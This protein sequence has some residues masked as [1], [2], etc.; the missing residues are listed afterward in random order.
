MKRNARLAKLRTIE[1]CII[2]AIQ[3]KATTLLEAMYY[4]LNQARRYNPNDVAPPA[5]VIWTDADGQWE[6][7][8]PELQELMPELLILGEYDPDSKQGPA[9]WI[10]CVVD[11]MLDI[12]LPSKTIPV[13]YLPRVPRQTLRAAEEC[14]DMLKPLVE[15]QYRGMVWTQRNGKDWTVEAMLVS[16]DGLGLDVAKDRQTRQ[17][18][19]VALSQLAVTPIERLRGKRLEAEDFDRLMLGD[20]ERELLLWIN[21]PV[22]TKGEWGDEKWAAFCSRCRADYGFDPESDGELV[23]AEKLGLKEKDRWQSL[24]AR[25][26]EAP[27]LYPGIPDKLR[28]AKP[29]SLVFDY[30][31][32][33]DFNEAEE[34]SLREDLSELEKSS[35]V[36]ARTRIKVLE[37]RHGLRREWVWA[38]LGESPLAIALEHLVALAEITTRGIGGSSPEEMA[39]L[40]IEGGYQADH[41]ALMAMGSIRTAEDYGAIQ[42]AVRSIYLPWLEDASRHLQDLMAN[43]PLPN[44]TSDAE[45]LVIAEPGQCLLFVD[46]L[47]F[48][49]AQRLIAMA[50]ARQLQTNGSWRWAG[51]PTVTSTAKPIVS[52]IRNQL[53]GEQPGEDFAPRIRGSGTILDSN[54]LK[55]L[56][57]EAGYQVL[58][59]SIVEQPDNGTSRGWAEE[60]EFDRLGHT[61][62]G[63]LATQLDEQLELVL[64]RIQGLLMSGWR[65]VRVIT[66]HGWLLVPGGLPATSLPKYLT[67]SRWARCA[68]IGPDTYVDAPTYGWYWNKYYSVAFAPGVSCFV[69]GNDYAHGGVS[70]QEC[71]IPDLTFSLSAVPFTDVD[72]SELKWVGMRCRVVTDA[73]SGDIMADLR[74]KP[75]DAGSSIT[76]PKK[77][78]ADGRVSLLV[79][80]DTLEGTVVSLVL[81]DQTER[82]LAKLTTTV[83]GDM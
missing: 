5:A 83:G 77:I 39:Q 71:V 58:G 70:L 8:V 51:L 32:W 66:D 13:I 14:P 37:S 24:W 33:P 4:L 20:T 68:A 80:D 62:Q 27:T 56:M 48:D 50:E 61:L 28:R 67:E 16:Q 40:Y 75:N 76:T 46:G 18:M 21:D 9:I 44:A 34:A 23:A 49:L 69:R 42:V 2:V 43:E 78:D 29:T 6:P 55:K 35:P 25:Y 36:D 12:G 47:R 63:K 60:G 7:I 82:V 19:L 31:P 38:K 74:T 64:D 54:R 3:M 57:D 81:T 72:I 79:A 59:P 73:T 1:E 65:Q 22:S 26:A 11:G 15:L 30:E 41:A 10:R 53:E 52:P 17:A 45:H